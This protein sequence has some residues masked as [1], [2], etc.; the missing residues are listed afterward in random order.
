MVLHARSIAQ[1]AGTPKDMIDKVCK[2]M[3][4]R[5]KYDVE[6]AKKILSELQKAKL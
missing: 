5:K 2:E 6:T 3:A 1:K 4:I